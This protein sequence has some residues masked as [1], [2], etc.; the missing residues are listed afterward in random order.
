MSGALRAT[1]AAAIHQVLDRGLSLEPVLAEALE[2]VAPR[3]RGLLR[4]LVSGSVR[5]A[6]RL[7]PVLDKLLTR[8]FKRQDRI[9]TSLCLVGLYQLA[10]TR[11][12]A[13][14]AVAETVDAT[15][16][17][18]KQRARGL[19]N[20]VLR[21][22]QREQ[23]RLLAWVDRDDASRLAHPRW[24]LEAIREDWPDQWPDILAA[25]NA[26]APMWLR[27]NRQ[28]WSRDQALA[29]LAEADCPA[30]PHPGLP[31]ALRLETPMESA[32]LP[33]FA[34]GRL[35]VQDAA[36]QRAASLL[37]PQAGER[38]LDACAAPG[39]KSGYLLELGDGGIRL[40]A[41]DRDPDRLRSVAATLERLG[42]T[43]ELVAGD[44][45]APATWWD[46]EPFDAIL[47]DAPC[48]ATG[49]IRRH[50][51]IKHH[52]RQTDIAA[53]VATQRRLL[54]AA[55]SM[56]APGGRLLYATCSLLHAENA[57]QVGAFL[58]DTSDAREVSLGD[59]FG[60][61]CPVGRQV[62][63][64]EA[65]EDGFYYACLSRQRAGEGTDRR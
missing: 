41:V 28:A 10:E 51:D 38:V 60:Q 36:A 59:D 31:H 63:P 24:L 56:L 17:L 48:S 49:V 14:A 37:A 57:G 5:W 6:H 4:E 42:L 54:D 22:F 21:R 45:G 55:W 30:Q 46:G 40:T 13:H 3:D 62:L 39:G 64:G 19:V 15:A 2:Q 26:H 32:R 8:P 52:R 11:V 1:A 16:I 9:L 34:E 65:G 47:L 58:G 29:A 7:L 44:A 33:G 23:T 12:P 18:D 53:M 35:S 61:A 25:G 20:A 27:V 43:A 50:P